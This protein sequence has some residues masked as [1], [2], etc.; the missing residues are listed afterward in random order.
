MNNFLLII[1]SRKYSSTIL[2]GVDLRWEVCSDLFRWP[3]K[4]PSYLKKGN[5][6]CIS[7]KRFYKKPYSQ[8]RY[9]N[10]DLMYCLRYND[11]I[12]DVFLIGSNT[13]PK[14]DSFPR[15]NSLVLQYAQFT[16]NT[17]TPQIYMLW[18]SDILFLKS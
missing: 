4:I 7:V 16:T 14:T 5:E 12:S 13:S 17:L 1:I 10:L 9:L 8:F 11:A 3:K 6:I 18:L 2:H 15:K